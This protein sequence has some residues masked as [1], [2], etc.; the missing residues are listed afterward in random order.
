MPPISVSHVPVRTPKGASPTPPTY[1][2]PPG[3]NIL[4][5]SAIFC[6]S[7]SMRQIVEPKTLQEAIVYFADLDTCIHYLA[8][9]RWPDGV[10]VCPTCG[11]RD[12]PYVE[13]RRLWQCKRRHPK[14][15]FSVKVGTVFE[16]SPIALSK[17]LMAMWMVA[18]CKNGVS[19]WE[20]HRSL[21]VTQKTAWFMLHR[22]RLALEG[23]ASHHLG[24]EHGGPVEIDETYVGGNR[25]NMHA[26]RRLKMQRA[27]KDE[28]GKTIVMGILDRDLRQVRA[29]VIPNV[30]RETLQAEILANVGRKSEIYTDTLTGYDHL[31]RSEQEYVHQTVNHMLEYV[32]GQV[33][34]QGIENFWSLLKRGLKGTYVSV[35]PFH[36]NRYVG[37]Q[38]FRYNNR[39]TRDNPLNDSD[40]FALA[41]SQIVGKRLTYAELTGKVEETSQPF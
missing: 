8:A 11:E 40:R 20:I 26:S 15:Q 21:D 23:K 34:T 32:R 38:I 7:V 13:A 37:E 36:L 9:K 30:K 41:V 10:A 1:V 24:G 33:H 22:I 31:G 2:V 18:N 28:A 27:M 5:S 12:V 4:D 19:S 25:R 35:E 3:T 6:Q 14:C 16:D 17:W 29:K 39:A